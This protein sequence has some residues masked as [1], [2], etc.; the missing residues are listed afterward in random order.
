MIQSYHFFI[1]G[2]H[3][4]AKNRLNL[5]FTLVTAEEREE[6]VN[7]YLG[8]EVSQE[9]IDQ[10]NNSKF[11][12]P[13]PHK[14]T[15]EELETMANYMLYG[16]SKSSNEFDLTDKKGNNGTWSIVDAGYVQI[17]TRNSP[18]A[19]KQEDSLDSM[20]ETASET[21][22]ALEL[23]GN[24]ISN[25]R[26]KG[27]ERVRLR[28]PKETFSREEARAAL[29]DTDEFL[30]SQFESL[31]KQI[32]ILE[33]T[34]TQWEINCGKRKK[35]IRDELFDRLTDDDI[36][37]AQ[38]AA[39]KLNLYQWSKQRKFLVELR[40]QQYTLRDSYAPVH[41]PVVTMYYTEAPSDFSINFK[42]ILPAGLKTKS[43]F[44]KKIFMSNLS[45]IH[46]SPN[47]QAP[48]LEYVLDMDKQHKLQTQDGVFDFR[49]LNHVAYLVYARSGLVEYAP[50]VLE[51]NE[52]L[53]QLLDTLDY[54]IEAA[55]LS[56]LHKDILSLKSAGVKNEDIADTINHNYNKTYSANYISTL[57][58]AKCCG[59][60]VEAADQ[61]WE[62]ID[63][64]TLGKEEFKT[65]NTCNKT[66]LRNPN[67]FVRKSRA[68][69]GLASRCKVCD[70]IA[71]QA[72]NKG[73]S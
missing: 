29:K 20:F 16:K 51:E 38:A 73:R 60:I 25:I 63:K 30:L 39:K 35:E 4:M 19:R 36:A 69:D 18:W 61:H 13:F 50:E 15:K 72:K 40:Q 47:L 9:L 42:A 26:G 3:D 53:T 2:R 49:N 8:G 70:K 14:P 71:R 45:D 64:M 54:Y 55:Q 24:M 59:G 67:N 22:K 5:D 43:D 44:S 12:F 17:P 27:S 57:F 62:I 23:Q 68:A 10:Y 21:G 37:Q 11:P 33:F 66:L 7:G 56:D 6:F 34:I 46:F 41:M 48:L 1:I 58:R 31:W 32:D 28:K 52:Y 65:C